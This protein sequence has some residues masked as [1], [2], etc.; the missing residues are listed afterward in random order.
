MQIISYVLTKL[1]GICFYLYYRILKVGL[2]WQLQVVFDRSRTVNKFHDKTFVGLN[3]YELFSCGFQEKNRFFVWWILF[4]IVVS[5]NIKMFSSGGNMSEIQYRN[6]TTNYYQLHNIIFET[7]SI[8]NKRLN[9]RT[10]DQTLLLYP[11][12][13]MR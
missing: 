11:A 5:S 3:K 12:L 6:E 2:N 8:K 10:S 7:R 13:K 1:V 4:C 9:A